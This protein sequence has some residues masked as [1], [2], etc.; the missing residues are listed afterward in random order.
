MKF[1]CG[2]LNE[3]ELKRLEKLEAKNAKYCARVKYLTNWHEHFAWLPVRVSDTDC[4]W[5]EKV[6]RKGKRIGH[7]EFGSWL[8]WEY[9]TPY[10]LERRRDNK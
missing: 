2:S 7:P 9:T 10:Y 8:T 3:K 6:L 4:R 5:L 1:N